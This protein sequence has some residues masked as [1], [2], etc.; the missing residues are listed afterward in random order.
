MAR[1]SAH[2]IRRATS[3]D[4]AFLTDVAVRA[5]RGRG[6]LPPDFDEADYRSGFA[7]WTEEQVR[8]EIPDSVTS[9]V[10]VDGERVARLR[11]VRTPEAVELAGIQLLP[12]YQGRGIG[13]AI[14]RSLAAEARATG[15]PLALSVEKDNPRARAF[16]EAYGMTKVDETDD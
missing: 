12:A 13:G 10:E 7:E 16:Y 3:D 6:P 8:G 4:V 5:I 14:L 9:V 1:P 11:V 2:T 15:R